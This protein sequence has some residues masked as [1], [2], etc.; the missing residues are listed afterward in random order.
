[1]DAESKQFVRLCDEAIAEAE[2]ALDG[3]Q[4][5]EMQ[6]ALLDVV[7]LTIENL[8]I[9]RQ[10]TEEGTLQRPSGGIGFGISRAV[11]EWAD[12]S[13]LLEA[14]RQLERFYREHM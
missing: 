3:I 12:G 7:T 14:V 13:P 5:G 1:M 8:L 10:H 9:L 11:G 2:R 4:Q 6:K